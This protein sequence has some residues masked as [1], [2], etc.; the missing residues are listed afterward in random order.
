[1][2]GEE[3]KQNPQDSTWTSMQ[4]NK[5]MLGEEAKQNPQ[6]STQTSMQ[7]NKKKCQDLGSQTKS[8]GFYI[9]FNANSLFDN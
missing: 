6:D 3:A 4:I 2:L 8:S 7:I 1:M 9:D 5:K